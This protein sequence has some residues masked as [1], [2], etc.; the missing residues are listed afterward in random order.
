MCTAAVGLG[1]VAQRGDGMCGIAH[2][3][4]P[5]PGTLISAQ[6]KPSGRWRGQEG[7]LRASGCRRTAQEEERWWK[8]IRGLSWGSGD[9]Q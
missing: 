9:P 7:P 2:C 1:A 5:L 4:Q 6:A 8:H 3:A